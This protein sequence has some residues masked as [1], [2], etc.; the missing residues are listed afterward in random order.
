MT[1]KQTPT[2]PALPL[3]EAAVLELRHQGK[4]HKEIA[5]MLGISEKASQMALWRG[6]KRLKAMEASLRNHRRFAT[7]GPSR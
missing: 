2:F 1:T 4:T 3:R 5:G 6:T 7:E